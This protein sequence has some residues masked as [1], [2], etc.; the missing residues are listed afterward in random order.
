M[1]DEMKDETGA[2]N[3]PPIRN[4][5]DKLIRDRIDPRPEYCHIT[6]P[7]RLEN[8]TLNL[9]NFIRSF[10]FSN[11]SQCTVMRNVT[12][13]VQTDEMYMGDINI[14]M[15]SRSG[16]SVMV[17]SNIVI[18]ERRTAQRYSEMNGTWHEE[19]HGYTHHL[20]FPLDQENWGAFRPVYLD[21]REDDFHG[22]ILSRA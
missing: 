1:E 16:E 22:I 7:S 21:L 13:V 11:P 18:R 12:F 15:R 9:D 3:T 17:R 5:F 14:G 2:A 10:Y 20:A 19:K 6:L 8:V 4:Y